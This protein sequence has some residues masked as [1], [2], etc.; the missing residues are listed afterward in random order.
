MSR[1]III[2]SICLVAIFQVVFYSSFPAF[3]FNEQKLLGL[4]PL[5][6]ERLAQ[7]DQDY[8]NMKI[9]PALGLGL[10]GAAVIN[11]N[12]SEKILDDYRLYNMVTG[13]L[14]V[15]IGTSIYFN[16]NSFKADRDVLESI[17]PPGPE[18]EK[19][20]YHLF[21][22]YAERGKTN[23]QNAGFLLMTAGLGC[24]LLPSLAKDATSG[25]KS[26]ISILGLAY[27]GL[28]LYNYFMPSQEEKDIENVEKELK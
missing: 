9:W 18:R 20:A 6:S 12:L 14:F 17:S 13:W 2:T 8:E 19:Y 1:K 27:A 15:S 22:G 10:L 24:A 16:K 5:L 25:Y 26:A 11:A 3:A 28:G 21:K 4:K 23:R 7:K